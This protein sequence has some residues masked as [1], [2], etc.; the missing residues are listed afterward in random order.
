MPVNGSVSAM[1]LMDRGTIVPVNDFGLVT[2]KDRTGKERKVAYK[3]HIPIKIPKGVLILA[4]HW[5]RGSQG[6]RL[7]VAG[8]R[9]SAPG[10][11]MGVRKSGMERLPSLSR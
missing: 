8:Q 6:P 10:L 2:G 1:V 11:L 3:D 9:L 7:H 4:R 5:T